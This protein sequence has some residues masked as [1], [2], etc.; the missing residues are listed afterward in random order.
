MRQEKEAMKT[1]TISKL[2]RNAK[3][4]IHLVHNYTERGLLRACGRTLSGYR[5]YDASALERLRWIRAGR[6]AGIP[7]DA[8]AEVVHALDE[9]DERRMAR[10]VAT[11]RAYIAG[12]RSALAVL[13]A[14]L[15][16]LRKPPGPGKEAVGIPRPTPR[17][18]RSA[19]TL[20]TLEPITASEAEMPSCA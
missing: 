8:L 1:Y 3:V 9:D 19:G 16:V 12:V 5:I 14:A 11:I 13:D 4:S 15:I 17:V 7:L 6:A 2:A 18:R 20:G 10:G